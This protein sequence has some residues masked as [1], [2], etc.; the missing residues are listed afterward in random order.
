MSIELDLHPLLSP[1]P[2]ASTTALP[3]PVLA[4]LRG[5]AGGFDQLSSRS[6]QLFEQLRKMLGQDR[7]QSCLLGIQHLAAA[8]DP[9]GARLLAALLDA[10]TPGSQLMPRVQR[11][12]SVH[13]LLVSD[14]DRVGDEF[15]REWQE[16]LTS[17]LAA[18]ETR[19]GA[20]SAGAVTAPLDRPPLPTLRHAV[21]QLL[22]GNGAV[23]DLTAGDMALLAAMVRLECDAYQERVSRL[24]GSIDPFRVTAVM[25]ALPLLNRADGE[26]RDLSQLANW[27]EAG[28]LESAFHRRIPRE[29]EVLDES[30]RPGLNAAYTTNAQLA[31]L[32]ALRRE[33]LAEPMNL[34]D[35]VG[36]AAR[37]LALGR[38]LQRRGLRDHELDLVSAIG[39]VLAHRP[40]GH[41]RLDLPTDLAATVGQV[42][43]SA[44]GA[45]AG[46]LRGLEL[47]GT[48]LRVAEPQLGLG[49]RVW[50]H[51][52]PTLGE[53]LLDA[54][55]DVAGESEA[56]KEQDQDDARDDD[57]SAFAVKQMVLNNVGSVSILLGFLRNQKVTS[58]PGLVA[59]V[60]RRTRSGRVLEVVAS[61]RTLYTGHPNKD[62]PRALLESPVNVSVK[63]LRR[64]IH[65]KYVSK[66]DLRRM[67]RDKSRL[68]KDVCREI[69][70][71]LDSLS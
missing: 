12:R 1:P 11:F 46:W 20:V 50:R 69:D 30:E 14:P 45:E 34:R 47:D 13:R 70:Q 7:L 59:D 40:T 42:L 17:L 26:I 49:D 71:Y 54:E 60:V 37:L 55:S 33:F 44:S 3:E 15:L 2:E 53:M 4:E 64:F 28:D 27:L 65:V 10:R 66:T 56:D 52:L 68:R 9:A 8:G 21:D 67:A 38:A 29:H 19:C 61:D 22:P 31:P 39:L 62:V 48:T 51:D 6:R 63:M 57:T 41:F 32:A 43:M 24:A 36:P 25:R 23:S 35:L 16:R 5:L 18:V 58:I